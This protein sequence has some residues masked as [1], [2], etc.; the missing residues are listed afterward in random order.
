MLRGGGEVFGDA[1]ARGQ[2]EAE[3][4]EEFGHAALGARHAAQAQLRDLLAAPH[5]QPKA[6]S[7]PKGSTSM[8]LIVAISSTTRRA[9]VPRPLPRIHISKVRHSASAREAD[10]DVRFRARGGLVVNRA[11]AEVALGGAEGGFGLGELNMP[12][13]ELRLARPP[14]AL[15]PSAASAGSRSGQL[16]RKR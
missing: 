15:F 6:L 7:L 10:G 3:A 1:A 2:L 11:Q 14:S 16:V 12:T 5:G 9:Q 4:H 8:L 13:P